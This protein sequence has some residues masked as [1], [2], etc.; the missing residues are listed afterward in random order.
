MQIVRTTILFSLMILFPWTWHLPRPVGRDGPVASR[1]ARNVQKLATENPAPPGFTADVDGDGKVTDWDA[2]LLS[3]DHDGDGDIDLY[4]WAAWSGA[5]HVPTLTVTIPL[6]HC[7]ALDGK[8][9]R[10]YRKQH[11][12]TPP[13]DPAL[14]TW[15]SCYPWPLELKNWIRYATGPRA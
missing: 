12:C 4:D 13:F 7:Q 8:I 11:E 3:L 10:A 14:P 6:E 15:F 2:A 9:C 1:P 5:F